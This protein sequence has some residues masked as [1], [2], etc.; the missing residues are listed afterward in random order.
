MKTK[1]K[2]KKWISF[3]FWTTTNDESSYEDRK[4]EKKKITKKSLFY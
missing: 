4:S 1:W 3:R 2:S